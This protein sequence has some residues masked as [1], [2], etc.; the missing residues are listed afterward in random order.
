MSG[1]PAPGALVCVTGSLANAHVHFHSYVERITGRQIVL[2]RRRHSWPHRYRREAPHTS[3][4]AKRWGPL[5]MNPTCQRP[6][7]ART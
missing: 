2:R 6:K 1:E 7:G 4:P 5:T 3:L